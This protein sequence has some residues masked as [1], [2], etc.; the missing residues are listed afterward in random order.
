M[1]TRRLS[2]TEEERKTSTESRADTEV[3]A[4]V[5]EGPRCFRSRG[6]T[7]SL[8]SGDSEVAGTRDRCEGEKDPAVTT[9]LSGCGGVRIRDETWRLDV[10]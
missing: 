9:R 6:K 2:A 7:P 5:A 4:G 10:A 1:Q 8:T 3:H